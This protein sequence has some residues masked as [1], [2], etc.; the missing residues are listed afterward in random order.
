VR[1]PLSYNLKPGFTAKNIDLIYDSMRRRARAAFKHQWRH[2][3]GIDS[4]HLRQKMEKAAED[5]ETLLTISWKEARKWADRSTTYLALTKEQAERN[6]LEKAQKIVNDSKSIVKMYEGDCFNKVRGA[7]H[8]KIM[9]KGRASESTW[10]EKMKTR[11]RSIR[12]AYPYVTSKNQHRLVRA[13][14]FRLAHPDQGRLVGALTPKELLAFGIPAA[15]IAGPWWTKDVGVKRPMDWVEGGKLSKSTPYRAFNSPTISDWLQDLGLDNEDRQL[16]NSVHNYYVQHKT[17]PSVEWARRRSNELE[18]ERNKLDIEEKIPKVEQWLDASEYW[19]R[20]ADYADITIPEMPDPTFRVLG[21]HDA[22]MLCKAAKR[23]GLCVLDV[24]SDLVDEADA[25]SHPA[26]DD[27]DDWFPEALY[28]KSK[29]KHV[30][31]LVISTDPKRRTVVGLDESG[32][33]SSEHHCTGIQ[34]KVDAVAWEYF[35]K[36]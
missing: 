11:L 15:E 2:F 6:R 9:T 5:T 33:C 22:E 14:R 10:L 24:L 29:A 4:L 20:S 30:V 28:K 13:L 34:N 31:T 18:E 19:R 32:H 17:A 26:F 12:T 8:I 27:Y 7:K 3:G 36:H 25:T 23:D 16:I 35:R 1:N 21:P